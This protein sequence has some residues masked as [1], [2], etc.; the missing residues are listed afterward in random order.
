[1]GPLSWLENR[2][3][4][5]KVERF[6]RAVGIGP[7]SWFIDRSRWIRCCKPPSE[8]EI[9]PLSCDSERLRLTTCR[10]ELH[11]IPSH[12]QKSGFVSDQVFNTPFGSSENDSFTFK[13]VSRVDSAEHETYPK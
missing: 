7:L 2:S 9:D 11:V 8:G 3:K 6:E 13:S 1:M 10:A 12:L 4:D 5:T